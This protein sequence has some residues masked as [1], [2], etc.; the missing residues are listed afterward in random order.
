MKDQPKEIHVKLPEPEDD[1]GTSVFRLK[2]NDVSL[3]AVTPEGQ[4]CAIGAWVEDPRDLEKMGIALIAA[5][6][7][8][9]RRQQRL[10]LRD[11]TR[12]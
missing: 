11:E 1:H 5:A 2:P 4:I 8:A 3:A 10:R 6:R 9:M 12:P 7:L